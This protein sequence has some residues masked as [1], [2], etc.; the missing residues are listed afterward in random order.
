MFELFDGN[1]FTKILHFYLGYTNQQL[2]DLEAAK[3]SYEEA[4]RID[5]KYF[6][7]Q[8]FLSR[9]MYMDVVKIK[10]EIGALGFS[11]ADK[12]KRE[13]LDKILVQKLKTAL[14]YWEKAEQIN[15][16]DRDVL[17]ALY[18]IYGDLD[19]QEQLKRVEKKMKELGYDN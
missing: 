12:K 6:D 13:D 9:I 5:P 8:L 15:N 1:A 7:A 3:K 2:N 18:S 14:P 10:K 11:A 17:D 4:L 16:S 19:M